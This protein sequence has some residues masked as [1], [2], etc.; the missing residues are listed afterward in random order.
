MPVTEMFR[1][2]EVG[3]TQEYQVIGMRPEV[4]KLDRRASLPGP[5]KYRLVDGGGS[6]D[7][8]DT[9]TFEIVRTGKR[10]R[11]IT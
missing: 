7:M 5:I 8:I 4:S 6:L 9:D 10:V 1:V 11:R 3:G 2:R